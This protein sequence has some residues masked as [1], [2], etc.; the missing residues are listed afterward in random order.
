[1]KTR[2]FEASDGFAYGKFLIGVFDEEYHYQPRLAGTMGP[3]ILR[4]EG[5]DLG[6][7]LLLDLSK[8][9]CGAI[10]KHDPKSVA[11]YDVRMR[12]V[13]C[14]W[15]YVPFL[16]WVYQQDLAD[17]DQWPELIHFENRPSV[18]RGKAHD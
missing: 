11:A 2:I 5:I 7:F 10:F 17:F 14:C 3:N 16:D 8:P 6:S 9:G 1:M 15:L 18:I 13:P 12:G 4:Q